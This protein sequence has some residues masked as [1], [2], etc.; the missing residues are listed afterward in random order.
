MENAEKPAVQYALV[1]RDLPIFVQ[2]VHVGHACGDAIRVAPIS[3]RTV[4]RLLHVNDER[5]LLAYHEKLVAPNGGG[6]R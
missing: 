2:M 5:E 4:L 1:R 3:G 6:Q